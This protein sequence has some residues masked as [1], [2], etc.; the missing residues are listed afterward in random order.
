M[1]NQIKGKILIIGYDPSI[2]HLFAN[3]LSAQIQKEIEVVVADI[4]EAQDHLW[5]VA[6]KDEDI[7]KFA[8][9]VQ[10]M[11]KEIKYSPLEVTEKPKWKG[12]KGFNSARNRI[13]T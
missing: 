12:K 13:I 11:S 2:L 8:A 1:E 6:S 10:A 9:S 7:K 5:H 4:K 3:V